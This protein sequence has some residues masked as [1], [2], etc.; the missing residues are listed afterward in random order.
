MS[1]VRLPE[2]FEIEITAEIFAKEAAVHHSIEG[3]QEETEW[4]MGHA[5]I[6]GAKYMRKIIKA[7]DNE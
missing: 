5:F 1:K 6:L 2:D 3:Q 7:Q 4:I